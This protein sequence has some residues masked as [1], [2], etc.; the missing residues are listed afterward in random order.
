[1]MNDKAEQE[2]GVKSMLV[3]GYVSFYIQHST[4]TIVQVRILNF[5]PFTLLIRSFLSEQLR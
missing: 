4:T 3:S 1:M 5:L 2:F